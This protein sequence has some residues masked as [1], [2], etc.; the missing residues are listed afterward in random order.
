MSRPWL[1]EGSSLSSVVYHP[2]KLED[3]LDRVTDVTQIC[4]IPCAFDPSG[5]GTD[6]G[7]DHPGHR[8]ARRV[9]YPRGRG[10]RLHVRDRTGIGASPHHVVRWLGSGAGAPGSRTVV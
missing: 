10:W 4:S 6:S 8:F 2:C 5:A 3:K 7:A 9:D 1:M